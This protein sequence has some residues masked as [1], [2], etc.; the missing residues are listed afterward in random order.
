MEQKRLLFY[1]K[2]AVTISPDGWQQ[3]SKRDILRLALHSGLSHSQKNNNVVD[4]VSSDSLPPTDDS[5]GISELGLIPESFMVSKNQPKSKDEFW[6]NWRVENSAEI[7]LSGYAMMV[8]GIGFIEVGVTTFGDVLLRFLFSGV[9]T[10]FGVK[11]VYA[12]WRFFCNIVK[13]FV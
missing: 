3:M 7:V 5:I 11:L 8:C 10:W 4:G 13:N 9:T 2:Y 6:E 12:I 1:E